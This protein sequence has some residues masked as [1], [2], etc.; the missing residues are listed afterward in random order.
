MDK[1]PD[2]EPKAP[3]EPVD[4]ALGKLANSKIKVPVEPDTKIVKLQD[5]PRRGNPYKLAIWILSLVIL[6]MAAAIIFLLFCPLSPLVE[7]P[8]DDQ[9]NKDCPEVADCPQCEATEAEDK[10]VRE[11][12]QQLET[13]LAEYINA[14]YPDNYNLIEKNYD[15]TF[16][17]YAPE[18]TNDTMIPLDRSYSLSY[19]PSN[20]S[21]PQLYDDL[22]K[23]NTQRMLARVLTDNG[24]KENEGTL[25]GANSYLNN[26]NILCSMG[27]GGWPFS[28]SCG[29]TSWV[30]HTDI[31]L[32]GELSV[33]YQEKT[34]NSLGYV[35]LHDA[36]VEDS[37]YKPYQRLQVGVVDA[38]GLFY[39][40]S[41]DS[42]WQF[43]IATQAP[44]ACSDFDTDDLKRAFMGESCYME[45]TVGDGSQDTVKP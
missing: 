13:A 24:F 12:L 17:Y 38:L 8:K 7:C 1:Q 4:P 3:Q 42:K 27:M 34:G 43:F 2:G 19:A 10:A 36:K 40:T 39:R 35:T 15:T 28:V 26:Q 25:P 11:V 44:L 18:G 16:P 45:S 23:G 21:Y 9:A 37:E 33:A 29:S 41:P 31:K 22:M 6:G 5:K 30:D 32:A 14:K 20:S